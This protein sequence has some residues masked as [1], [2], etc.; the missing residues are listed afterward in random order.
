L[1][2]PIGLQ[3]LL[4]SVKGTTL[5]TVISSLALRSLKLAVYST[6]NAGHFGLA[7]KSYCHFTSPIRR[8]PD[9]IVHRSLKALLSN[10]QDSKTLKYEKLALHCSQ[11]ERVAEKA[12]RESQKVM[13]LRFMEN[14]VY[15]IFEGIVKH[16]TPYGAYV[17]LTP[18][19][20]EGF[21]PMENMRDDDYRF[22]ANTMV[23][24]GQRGSVMRI[25]DKMSVK[26]LAVDMIFQRLLL[27]KNYG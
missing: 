19:G 22:D 9:L 27:A 7:L 3:G 11:K 18:Y 13:Q 21:L 10:N 17:E 26:V 14:K 23:L 2:T 20:I 24:Q 8:Y 25:T 1:T 6:R 5:E 15:Q 16:L 12:E 4:K